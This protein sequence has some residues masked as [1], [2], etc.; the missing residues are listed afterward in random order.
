MSKLFRHIF[1]IVLKKTENLIRYSTVR[2]LYLK[3][4]SIK[5]TTSKVTLKKLFECK[6]IFN[7]KSKFKL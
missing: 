5:Q 1:H 6:S 4:Q 2:L 7:N 3:I